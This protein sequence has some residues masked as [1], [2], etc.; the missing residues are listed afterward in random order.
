MMLEDYSIADIS[1]RLGPSESTF[2]RLRRRAEKRLLSVLEQDE[3]L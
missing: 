1:A 2:K 3:R